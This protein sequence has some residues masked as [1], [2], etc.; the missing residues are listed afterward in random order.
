M[1]LDKYTLRLFNNKFIKIVATNNFNSFIP[2]PYLRPIF[3]KNQNFPT[4]NTVK[5]N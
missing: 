2:M 5:I 1:D 3:S 4:N